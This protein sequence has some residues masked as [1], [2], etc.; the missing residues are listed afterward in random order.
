MGM[1]PTKVG[2]GDVECTSQ[3]FAF[4]EAF[5]LCPLRTWYEGEI[6]ESA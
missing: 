1:A 6:S 2:V 3:D 4:P 5:R